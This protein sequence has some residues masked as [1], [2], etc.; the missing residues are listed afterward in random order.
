M[1]RPH[2]S[3][4]AVHALATLGVGVVGGARQHLRARAIG[5]E[6]AAVGP[7]GVGLGLDDHPAGAVP[8]ARLVPEAVEQALRLARLVVAAHG[9]REQRVAGGLDFPVAGQP[10]QVLDAELL[11][12]GDHARHTVASVAANLEGHVG[13]GEPQALGETSQVVVGAQGRAGGAGP[14]RQHD[15]LVVVGGGDEAGEVLVLLE[16]AVEQR[17]LLLAVGGVVDGVDVDVDVEDEPS[18]RRLERGDELLDELVAQPNQRGMSMELSKRDRVGW[19]ARS[20]PSGERSAMSLKTGS[21]RRVSWSF[22]ST[23]SARTP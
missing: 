9:L 7:L 10:E 17:E 1:C 15:D 8:G 3:S 5:H 12:D 4:F 2:F 19:L 22:W 23:W 6:E 21:L 16:V 14:Q 18:R 13:P 20:R 11:A